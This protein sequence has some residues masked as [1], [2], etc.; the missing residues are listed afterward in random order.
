LLEIAPGA[1]GKDEPD[2]EREQK[3]GRDDGPIDQRK[4]HGRQNPR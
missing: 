2:S 3:L 4:L 1:A